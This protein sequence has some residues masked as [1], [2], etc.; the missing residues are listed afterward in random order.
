ME[1]REIQFVRFCT[2]KDGKP[3]VIPQREEVISLCVILNEW[4]AGK[5]AGFLPKEIEKQHTQN[6]EFGMSSEAGDHEVIITK[7][8]TLLR[9]LSWDT[10][11][12]PVVEFERKLETSRI[13]SIIENW[14]RCLHEISK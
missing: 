9:R 12:E 5:L 3:T 2:N 1:Y 11:H 6:K 7:S 4:S 14:D 13:I 8:T 10:K